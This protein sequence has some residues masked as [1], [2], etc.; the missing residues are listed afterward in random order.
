VDNTLGRASARA[1]VVGLAGG[2]GRARDGALV[3]LRARIPQVHVVG[4]VALDGVAIAVERFDAGR[5]REKAVVRWD[6]HRGKREPLPGF[7][8]DIELEGTAGCDWGCAGHLAHRVVGV[9][10]RVCRCVRAGR[11]NAV[12]RRE[13][14]D[15]PGFALEP[16]RRAGLRERF[17]ANR[18]GLA[19]RENRVLPGVDRPRA[20]RY[21]DLS[22]RCRVI[23]IDICRCRVLYSDGE[24][25]GASVHTV[26]HAI[27]G[28]VV[29]AIVGTV[30]GVVV[31][32]VVVAATTETTGE[33]EHCTATESA[34]DIAPSTAFDHAVE[35]SESNLKGIFQ[36]PD[37]IRLNSVEISFHI[38]RTRCEIGASK[39]AETRGEC[40]GALILL[41]AY[42]DA[43]GRV[44]ASQANRAH[45]V[46]RC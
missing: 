21:P 32:A 5:R 42:Q 34:N 30:V 15:Q 12:C 11:D 38:H 25:D 13:F 40:S 37:N 22:P 2:T 6:V 28:T 19:L 8:L 31:L 36:K 23:R 3:H 17:Q 9:L 46:Q 33:C 7:G 43:A 1:A 44:S 27:V 18:G 16:G 39:P 14:V 45:S 26:V 10:D 24:C 20:G 4:Y 29:H 35:S 41:T